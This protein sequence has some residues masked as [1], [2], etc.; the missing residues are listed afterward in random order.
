MGFT[1]KSREEIEHGAT[2]KQVIEEGQGIKD[3]D[4]A[5][6]L[7]NLPLA[8]H[9]CYL[10]KRLDKQAEVINLAV[11]IMLEMSSSLSGD[12]AKND[13]WQGAIESLKSHRFG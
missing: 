13:A 6:Q 5:L 10:Q 11:S 2:A 12:M 7:N 9:L 1:T 3:M 4:A 8:N